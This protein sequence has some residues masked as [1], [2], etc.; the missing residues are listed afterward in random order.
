MGAQLFLTSVQKQAGAELGQAQHSLGWIKFNFD[1][2]GLTKKNHRLF[3]G[4][5]QTKAWIMST[6]IDK[7]FLDNML[8]LFRFLVLKF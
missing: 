4:W 2:L 5:G 7:E 8:A 6:Q 3:L 1:G